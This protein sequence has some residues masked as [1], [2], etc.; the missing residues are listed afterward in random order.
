MQRCLVEREPVKLQQLCVNAVSDACRI[1]LRAA[2]PL[3]GFRN[4]DEQSLRLAIVYEAR[5]FAGVVCSFLPCLIR[6]GPRKRLHE[7]AVL[8]CFPGFVYRSHY[9]LATCIQRRLRGEEAVLF[10]PQP[11]AVAHSL[12]TE[13]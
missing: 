6:R 12:I 5:K 2:K 3:V 10:P 8:K 1:L 13:A 9:S 7:Q 4:L 11:E